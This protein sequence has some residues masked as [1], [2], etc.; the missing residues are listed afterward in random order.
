MKELANTEEIAEAMNLGSRI[1]ESVAG[2]CNMAAL[3][4]TAPNLPRKGI[5]L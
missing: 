5:R 4:V 1:N 2:L 3:I